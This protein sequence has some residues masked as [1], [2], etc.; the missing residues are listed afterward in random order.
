MSGNFIPESD[1]KQSSPSSSSSS[2]SSRKIDADFETSVSKPVSTI[3]L[4]ALLVNAGRLLQHPDLVAEPIPVDSSS[5]VGSASGF[6]PSPIV[7]VATA[8]DYQQQQQ[9]KPKK[10]SS[11]KEGKQQQQQHRERGRSQERSSKDKKT[12]KDRSF[13]RQ[14]HERISESNKTS[15]NSQNI[16]RV[17]KTKKD[18]KRKSDETPTQPQSQSQYIPS[19]TSSG[20]SL[21]FNPALFSNLPAPDIQEVDF[22]ASISDY[23]CAGVLGGGGGSYDES[24]DIVPI[25]INNIQ[26]PDGKAMYVIRAYDQTSHCVDTIFHILRGNV[27]VAI[28]DPKPMLVSCLTIANQVR[29]KERDF[30]R[31]RQCPIP[32]KDLQHLVADAYLN[33]TLNIASLGKILSEVMSSI[34]EL[35]SDSFESYEY[36][37]SIATLHHGAYF[38]LHR[39]HFSVQATILA[40]HML[41]ADTSTIHGTL[42]NIHIQ[43]KLM[44]LALSNWDFTNTVAHMFAEHNGHHPDQEMVMAQQIY[45][46]CDRIAA[47]LISQS[48][49][50]CYSVTSFLQKQSQ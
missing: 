6:V 30:L 2:S 43:R 29:K 19:S 27:D 12:S 31:L 25:G 9:E 20:V 21:D 42:I 8:E 4:S 38:I 11:T 46:D 50:I 18:K 47:R 16:V 13:S 44:G 3:I 22:N 14:A 1:N 48:Y 41:T 10:K 32:R 37:V 34:P 23:N 28:I 7:V 5:F 39:R 35:M 26:A 33:N 45:R 36:R 15:H 49:D 24:V 40:E 17:N